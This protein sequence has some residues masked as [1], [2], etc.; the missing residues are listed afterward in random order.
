MGCWCK[1]DLSDEPHQIAQFFHDSWFL[2]PLDTPGGVFFARKKGRTN[3]KMRPFETA[4]RPSTNRMQRYKKK[5]CPTTPL[6]QICITDRYTGHRRKN[7]QFLA[8]SCQ[9]CKNYAKSP[10]KSALFPL[11]R[12]SSPRPLPSLGP[13]RWLNSRE[14]CRC[15]RYGLHHDAHG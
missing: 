3:M 13:P 4:K 7:M 6:F 11:L 15:R 5:R 2:A 1:R 9:I 8:N 14:R 12:H 10:P